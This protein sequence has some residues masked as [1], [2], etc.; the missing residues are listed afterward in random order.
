MWL[1]N[2]QSLQAKLQVMEQYG[3]GGVA[4]WK[5]GYEAGHPEVWAVISDFAAG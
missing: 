1:E 3:I 5:L 2:E 4:A